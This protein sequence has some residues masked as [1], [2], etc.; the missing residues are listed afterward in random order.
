MGEVVAPGGRL[1]IGKF[2]EEVG[3][4]RVKQALIEWGFSVGGSVERAHHSEPRLVY[5]A[6]WLDKPSRP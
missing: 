2:N 5:R 4:H 1:I 3:E 6:V